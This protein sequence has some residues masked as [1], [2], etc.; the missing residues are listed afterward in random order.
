MNGW[1]EKPNEK[2]IDFIH[3]I[4]NNYDWIR[5]RKSCYW[6]MKN[7]KHW[8]RERERV[9]GA[10]EENRRTAKTCG[11]HMH[12]CQERTGLKRWINRTCSIFCENK[13][14]YNTCSHVG[15]G[16][17]DFPTDL[18]PTKLIKNWM[19]DGSGWDYRS[20]KIRFE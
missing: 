5:R 14:A 15:T 13:R 7:R 10:G 20:N 2:W 1:I 12:V 19:L 17:Q 16:G 6:K 18:N 3:W 8:E 11:C 4:K 9:P